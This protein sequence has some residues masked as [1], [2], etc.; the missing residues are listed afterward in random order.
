MEEALFLQRLEPGWSM[1]ET[2]R[3]KTLAKIGFTVFL[4]DLMIFKRKKFNKNF[5]KGAPH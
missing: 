4:A 3:S 1:A 2:E 5:H